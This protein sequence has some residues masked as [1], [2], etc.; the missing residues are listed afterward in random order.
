MQHCFRVIH[1]D[2]NYKKIDFHS[3]RH[4]HATLL[5]SSGVNIKAVQERLGHKKPN[6][7]LDVYTH[8]T[9][10]MRDFTLDVLNKMSN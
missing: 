10:E 8:V 6:I 1:Y 7:T 3:L 4:T 5:L 2:L 9:D